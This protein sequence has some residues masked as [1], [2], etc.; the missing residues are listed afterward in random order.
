MSMNVVYFQVFTVFWH[1]AKTEE[2]APSAPSFLAEDETSA[3]SA[4]SPRCDGVT[5]AT[6]EGM[7]LFDDILTVTAVVPFF[8]QPFIA[9]PNLEHLETAPPLCFNQ[10]SQILQPQFASRL[11][12]WWKCGKLRSAA[13][14]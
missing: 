1:Y 13:M 3:I 12:R 10:I 8:S 7:L 2:R 9:S 11:A 4:S 5:A 6:L 14:C